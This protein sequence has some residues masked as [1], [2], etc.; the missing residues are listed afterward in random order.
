MQTISKSFTLEENVQDAIDLLL[1]HTDPM[2][3]HADMAIPQWVIAKARGI[4]FLFTYKV[5]F[6]ASASGGSGILIAKRLGTQTWGLPI[7]LGLGG[8]GGGL[9]FGMSKSY[10][11]LVLNSDDAVRS[12]CQDNV[13]LGI[14]IAVAAGPVG[15]Q[16]EGT[17]NIKLGQAQQNEERM[18]PCFCYGH[19]KGLF[20]GI[21]VQGMF[22]T[23]KDSENSRYYGLPGTHTS[24]DMLFGPVL[25]GR[26]ASEATQNLW[27]ALHRASQSAS[28]ESTTILL[29]SNQDSGGTTT[30]P[31]SYSQAG[32]Y[33]MG[34]EDVGP[35]IAPTP[36]AVGGV[37]SEPADE[38]Q[39][40]TSVIPASP[41]TLFG[42]CSHCG[43]AF[44]SPNAKFCSSCGA[45]R[46]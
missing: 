17:A 41:Q 24:Q 46:G 37:S 45:S 21:G 29:Q 16:A 26:P 5:G 31:S 10:Q 7:G 40:P 33:N 43:S 22:L 15:R 32:S 20:A 19:T 42:F 6:F 3:S 11:I 27:Q 2:R 25:E 4:A 34:A 28:D 44:T 30:C 1:A 38:K 12:F 13:K 14:G 39:L 18:V 23:S 8:V 36:S 35:G 9:D